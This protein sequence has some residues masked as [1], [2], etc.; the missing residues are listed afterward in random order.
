MNL[1]A[2]WLIATVAA[3]GSAG[4]P[5]GGIR[6]TLVLPRWTWDVRTPVQPAGRVWLR[7]VNVGSEL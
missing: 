7:S 2:L 5:S 6:K 3:V 1:L 4:L